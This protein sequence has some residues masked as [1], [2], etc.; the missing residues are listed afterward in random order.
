MMICIILINLALPIF[1]FIT[2]DPILLPEF[3]VW[4]GD[5]GPVNVTVAPAAGHPVQPAHV[6]APT[7]P[8]AGGE[9]HAVVAGGHVAQV[10]AVIAHVEA[11]VL[12]AL[13]HPGVGLLAVL[14][15]GDGEGL[16]CVDLTSRWEHIEI[17][18][19]VELWKGGKMENME[20]VEMQK[21][22]NVEM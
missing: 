3:K 18:G 21:C 6:D 10:A 13:A 12:P 22:G 7:S 1:D 8:E 2:V 14:V 11:G 16:G 9:H 4:E 19:N 17:C 20:S 5:T 15:V